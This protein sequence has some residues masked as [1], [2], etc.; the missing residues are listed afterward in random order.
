MVFM[1]GG[2]DFSNGFKFKP[3]DETKDKY[4]VFNETHDRNLRVTIQEIFFNSNVHSSSFFL[5]DTLKSPYD[6]PYHC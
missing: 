3:P 6:G 5:N 4:F 2:V 1:G